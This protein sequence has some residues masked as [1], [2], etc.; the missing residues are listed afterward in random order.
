[1]K[2]SIFRDILPCSPLKVN[3]HFGQGLL[4]TFFTQIYYL[5][6]Y[7]SWRWGRSIPPKHL[8]WCRA[9]IWSP[10]PDLFSCMTISGFL[11]V[12]PLWRKDGSVI[13][14]YNCFWALPEQSL[15]GPSPADLTT[16]CYCLFWDSLN[17]EG[18]VKVKVEVILRLTVSRPVCLG[19]RPPSK[20]H[21][22][23]FITV[24]HMRSSHW[25]VPSLTSGRVCN[26]LV[27]F[28]VPLRS[29]SRRTHD[30]FLLS[31]LR[32]YFTVS[33]EA[34]PTLMARSL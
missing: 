23:I 6:Y 28:A 27:Q 16:I 33:Y 12:R 3:W 21:D 9:P 4:A 20:N 10:W 13:Y 18:Q 8:S 24:G 32:P 25:G 5:V 31:H 22:Q 1:M 7:R 14:S 2:S 30:H 11:S 17:L 26:L 29:K 15:S 34:P 19:V